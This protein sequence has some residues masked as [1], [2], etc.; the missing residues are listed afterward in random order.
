MTTPE[1]TFDCIQMKREAQAK[2]Y[3]IIKDMTPEQEIRYCRESVDR[4]EL[5]TWWRSI[6]SRTEHTEAH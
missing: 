5:A 3:E 6:P 1:K 2:I 4:S